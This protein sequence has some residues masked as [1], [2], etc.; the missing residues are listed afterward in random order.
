MQVHT[1]LGEIAIA[2]RVSKTSD[3]VP[4]LLK[5]LITAPTGRRLAIAARVPRRHCHKHFRVRRAR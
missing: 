5:L 2:W 1:N 4:L 3:L